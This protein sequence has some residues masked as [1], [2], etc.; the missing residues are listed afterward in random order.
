MNSARRSATYLLLVIACWITA[1]VTV[2]GEGPLLVGG[3][4]TPSRPQA[5]GQPYRWASDSLAFKPSTST[6]SYWTDMGTLGS[7]SKMQADQLVANAFKSWQDVTTASINFTK[8]GDLGADVTS[9]NFMTVLNAVNDCSTLPSVPAGTVAK[10]A[11]VIYDTDGRIFKAMGE[12]PKLVGGEASALCPTS[13]G[14]TNTYN[15]AVAILNGTITN[16]NEQSAIMVHE[17]GHMLGLDHSQI[18]LNCLTEP[19]CSPDQLAGVPIMFPVL[20]GSNPDGTFPTVPRTDDTA[21]ISALN[22]ETSNNPP[23]QV[24]FNTLGRIQ[25]RIFFTDGVTQAQGYNVIARNVTN[26]GT[27]AVSNVSGFLFTEDAGNSAVPGSLTEEPFGSHD[28]TLIGFF[29]IPGL[30]P[31]S[32]TIE[33][34]AINNSGKFAFVGGSAVGPIGTL[35]FQFAFPGS[36]PGKQFFVNPAGP[37]PCSQT[38]ATQVSVAAASTMVTTGVD[39]NFVGTGPRFDAWEDGP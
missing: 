39:I 20:L 17:F 12:D 34:E 37:D 29:D 26:P 10:P 30:P 13:N 3:P 7:L 27:V 16:T 2:R 4:P 6:L 15:R 8:A 5:E 31:G 38:N 32:Y 25:G 9:S 24:P 1:G 11:T 14:T 18:N 35:G 23:A 21:G 22:P 33:V 36:C 19:P 28:Q